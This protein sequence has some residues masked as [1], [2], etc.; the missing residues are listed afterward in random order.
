MGAVTVQRSLAWESEIQ[1]W[2]LPRPCC[3][4]LGKSP[5]SLSLN[6]HTVYRTGLSPTLLHIF[7]MAF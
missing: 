5:P 7:L 2:F 4:A 6:P 1:I 3:V